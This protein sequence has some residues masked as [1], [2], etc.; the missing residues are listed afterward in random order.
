MLIAA[1]LRWTDQRAIVDPLTGE[2]RTSTAG[3]GPSEADRCALEHGLRLAAALRGRCVAITVGPPAADAML[4]DA[5]AAGADAV[6][7]VDPQASAD[8]NDDHDGHR[9][10]RLLH[11]GLINRHGPPDVVVCGDRSTDRGTGSTPAFLAALLGAQQA[12]GLLELSTV[13]GF[14]ELAAVRRLDGG[15]RERLRIGLP[16]VCSVEPTDVRLR[17]A[18]LPA[19]LAA[20]GAPIPV[21][22]GEVPVDGRVRVTAV[23]PYRPRARVVANGTADRDADPHRR[24]VA[25]SGTLTRHDPP[26]LVTPESPAAAAGELLTFLRE[27]GYLA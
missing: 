13:D 4:R 8:K 15:R 19:V 1:A 11:Q 23:R 17:R 7:R 16:A 3:S 27:H 25:L 14:G 6:L 24:M 12:L 5:L 9:T 20:R 18:P 2:V 21:V 22:A 26:R 10:A